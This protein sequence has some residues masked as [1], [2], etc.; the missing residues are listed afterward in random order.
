MTLQTGLACWRILLK[1]SENTAQVQDKVGEKGKKWRLADLDGEMRNSPNVSKKIFK[2]IK[3]FGKLSRRSA[4]RR[5][6]RRARLIS[7][8][9]P[10]QL[11]SGVILVFFDQF[12]P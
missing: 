12:N 8:M 7:P 4:I 10:Y 5:S 9:G 2:K 1:V 11:F 6:G 3:H